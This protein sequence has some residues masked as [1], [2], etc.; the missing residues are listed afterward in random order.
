MSFFDP[1]HNH[2]IIVGCSIA[3]ASFG[4]GFGASQYFS[5]HLHKVES[6]E[7]DRLSEDVAVLH[8]QVISKDESI[9][10]LSAQLASARED[11]IN[12]RNSEGSNDV[13]CRMV[14]EKYNA[15]SQQYNEL[16]VIYVNL[17]S[18]YQKAQQNCNVLNR[19]GF[20]EQ[21]RRNLENQ[22]SAV[23]YDT[24]EKDPT[25]KKR[26]LQM[27]LVQNHEQLLNMQQQVSR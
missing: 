12:L 11:V 6:I 16:S 17:K 18:N 1:F 15:I 4:T 14:N 13:S 26:E 20:L 24:F 22:L 9:Q 5:D 21:Q 8:Q 10:T 25:G 23:Q 19:I 27:L 7:N 2:P 3:I